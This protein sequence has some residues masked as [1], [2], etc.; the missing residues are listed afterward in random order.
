MP[1]RACSAVQVCSRREWLVPA[2]LLVVA[3]C[4]HA[5]RAATGGASAAAPTR[6][7]IEF[8]PVPEVD[9]ARVTDPHGGQ[10][11]ALCQR[12][13]VAG[14]TAPSVDPIGLCAGCHDVNV[15]KHPVRVPQ[16]TGAEGLPLLPGRLIACHTCHDPHD[17]KSQRGGLRSEYVALCKKCHVGHK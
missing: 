16:A 6:P 4:G 2:L 13:H 7:A 14:E 17:V 9:A 8:T 3:G 11:T 1:L 5:P 12:C 10:G 15:M